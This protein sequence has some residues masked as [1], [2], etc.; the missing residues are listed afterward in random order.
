MKSRFTKSALVAA[1]LVAAAGCS[2][3]PPPGYVPPKPT[4]QAPFGSAGFAGQSIQLSMVKTGTVVAVDL[5]TRQ[6][7]IRPS[8]GTNVVYQAGPAFVEFEQVK[9]G[10]PARLCLSQDSKV[11]A[12]A[13]GVIISPVERI[14]PLPAPSVTPPGEAIARLR[15]FTAKV[16]SVDGWQREVT[17]QTAD[18]QTHS[19]VVR[20][21]FNVADVYPGD[22]YTVQ[23]NELQ[24]F[25]VG[26]P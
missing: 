15:E 26:S 5:S 22:V 20:E 8:E 23:M 13:P 9:I 18:G 6:I 4:D 19:L 2:S 3:K 24:Q 21:T 16:I 17:F 14:T 10:A 7:T 12:P 1:L 11:S 25:T